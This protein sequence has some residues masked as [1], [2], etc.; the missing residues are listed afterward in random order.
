ML[1]DLIPHHG[2]PAACLHVRAPLLFTWPLPVS[3]ALTTPVSPV[4]SL[5]VEENSRNPQHHPQPAPLSK[6]PMAPTLGKHVDAGATWRLKTK[7]PLRI[8]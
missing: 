6:H 4:V 1:P 8:S 7:L 3:L 5:G 2:T